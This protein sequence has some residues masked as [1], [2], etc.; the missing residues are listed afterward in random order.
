MDYSA[1]TECVRLHYT[2]QYD[3][4]IKNLCQEAIITLGDL[5]KQHVQRQ[6]LND[7]VKR[8]SAMEP[9]RQC[10]WIA[11]PFLQSIIDNYVL[12]VTNGVSGSAPTPMPVP[13]PVP[14]QLRA[15]APM[16]KPTPK[17][18]DDAEIYDIFADPKPAPKPDPEEEMTP[19]DLFG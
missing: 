8:L 15:P 17:P 19:F 14:T 13:I 12:Q 5:C 4:L 3:L 1:A 6:F 11:N 9:H 16:L 2:S 7:T 18:D 10:G